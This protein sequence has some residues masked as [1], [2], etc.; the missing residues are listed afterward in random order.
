MRGRGW[1]WQQRLRSAGVCHVT[2]SGQVNCGN[3]GV[4]TVMKW[5]ERKDGEGGGE[6]GR[7]ARRRRRVWSRVL[8]LFP[9]SCLSHSV[10]V[11]L[12]CKTIFGF[13][14]SLFFYCVDFDLVR[15]AVCYGV[16]REYIAHTQNDSRL[17]RWT[18]LRWTDGRMDRE[19]GMAFCVALLAFGQGMDGGHS[20]VWPGEGWGGETGGGKGEM[21][22]GQNLGRPAGWSLGRQGTTGVWFFPLL[23]CF[24]LS[25]SLLC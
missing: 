16:V 3:F 20:K 9:L 14:N 17:S 8:S 11:C 10:T 15:F 5:R 24:F 7:W 19:G 21:V 12:S 13:P 22:S 25:L 2:G 6:G 23:P 18:E 4:G 1:H